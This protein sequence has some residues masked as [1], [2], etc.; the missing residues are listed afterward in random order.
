MII[1]EELMVN[2][3]ITFLLS[4]LQWYIW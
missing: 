2:P 4:T 1:N 3:C